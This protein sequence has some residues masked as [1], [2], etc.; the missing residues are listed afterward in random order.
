MFQVKHLLQAVF[1]KLSLFLFLL[2]SVHIWEVQ[3]PSVRVAG[4]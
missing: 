3:S 4:E 1:S 2:A